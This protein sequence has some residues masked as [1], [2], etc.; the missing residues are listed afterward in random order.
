MRTPRPFPQESVEKVEEL[1]KKAKTKLEF[2]RIQCVWM[3]MKKKLSAPDIAELIGWCT[4]SVRRIH[5]NYFKNREEIFKGVGRGGRHRENLCKEAEEKLLNSFFDKA[6]DGGILVVHEIKLAYEQEVGHTVPKSTIY[7]MLRR[8]N[9]RKIV[10]YHRH[11]Q[12]D[13]AKQEEF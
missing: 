4:S 3:R 11:P 9:W 13:L 12:A 10:P 8:H 5:A 2:Q 6:K 1:L 7:R